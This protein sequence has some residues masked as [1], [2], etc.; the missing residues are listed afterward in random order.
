MYKLVAM[1]ISVN[2]S[3]PSSGSAWTEAEYA[4]IEPFINRRILNHAELVKALPGRSYS[5]ILGKIRSMRVKH[6]VTFGLEKKKWSEDE[7]KALLSEIDEN[8]PHKG[9]G[10]LSEVAKRL[11]RSLQSVHNKLLRIRGKS[12]PHGKVRK[13]P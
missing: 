6:N 11:G 8:H 12:K 5:A 3:K 1:K 13:A 2:R 9:A 7:L 10:S 4:V